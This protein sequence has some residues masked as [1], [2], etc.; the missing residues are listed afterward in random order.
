MI[1]NQILLTLTL[2]PSIGPKAITQILEHNT[3]DVFESPDQ[4]LN[5]IK[6]T[7]HYYKRIKVP[8]LNHVND[9]W[10]KSNEIIEKSESKNIKITN[11]TEETFPVSL[12]NIDDHPILIFTKGKDN[13]INK[14]SVAI[15]GTR[16]PSDFGVELTK[17]LA[18]DLSSKN[19]CIVS[20]L[21]K[22]ID[23]AAHIGAINGIGGTIAV[24][25]H[26]LDMVFPPENQRYYDI[27]TKEGMLLTEYPF[28]TPPNS[29][30]YLKRNRI[31]SGLSIATIVIETG[32]KGGTMTTA[33]YC[34]E[35]GRKLIVFDNPSPESKGTEKL[36]DSGK[37]DF[38]LDE[39]YDIEELIDFLNTQESSINSQSKLF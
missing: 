5:A 27:I 31:Q 22:G 10:N 25:G 33:K 18:L 29:G 13:I 15:V 3:V 1:D 6:K 38:V 23:T 28:N 12:K 17:N 34:K 11:F 7:K 16:N 8:E 20:G 19:C 21:A 35:H 2:I 32:E 26:G 4:I 30:T 24:L 36:I 9:A 39:D 37:A 14:T